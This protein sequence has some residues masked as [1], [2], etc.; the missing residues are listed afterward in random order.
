MMIEAATAAGRDAPVEVGASTTASSTAVFSA[1]FL[2]YHYHHY[3]QAVVVE[4]STF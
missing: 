1:G 3:A 2:H 4:S